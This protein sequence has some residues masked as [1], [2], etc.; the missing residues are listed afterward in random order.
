MLPG[1]PYALLAPLVRGVRLAA[2]SPR[3]ALW[4]TLF[5]SRGICELQLF[6]VFETSSSRARHAYDTPSTSASIMYGRAVM[7]CPISF[8]GSCGAS[9]GR[10]KVSH[11][12][13]EEYQSIMHMYEGAMAATKE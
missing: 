5:M 4:I 12:V 11:S 6:R 10:L 2:S 8:S 3:P 13:E 7:L 1:P 9:N